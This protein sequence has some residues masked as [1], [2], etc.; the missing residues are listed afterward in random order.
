MAMP[1]NQ[2]WLPVFTDFIKYLR[3]DSK[4]IAAVDDRG[5]ELNLWDSQLIFLKEVC[6]GLDKGIRY[7]VCLKSRQLGVTTISLV[8]DCF[9]LAMHPGTIGALVTDSDANR[10]AN[11]SV[12]KRYISSFPKGFF[13]S[14]FTIVKDNR[15]FME[16]SNGS[17]LDFLVAGTREKK[18][19]GEGRGYALAHLTEVA[20][21]GSQAGLANFKESLA[22]QNPNR[23]VIMES[24]AN[25]FNL[26]KNEWDEAGRDTHT[27]KR[28]FI[29]WWSKN[30]SR[31]EKDDPRYPIYGYEDPDPDERELMK[32]VKEEYDYT[33]K[34]EQLAWYRWK[35][36]DNS[37]SEA[38][39]LQNQPWMASQAFVLSGY[40]FFQVRQLQKD[41]AR[42]VD[43]DGTPDGEPVT[44]KGFRYWLG[45]DFQAGK[46]ERIVDQ[47]RLNEVE[48]RVWEEPVSGAQYVIGCD[49][50]FGRNDHKDRHGISVWR[51]YA[52][53]LVQVAEYA[54]NNVETRQAAWVLAFLAGTYRNCMV[55]IDLTGGPGRAVLT[56]FEHLKERMRSDMYAE[57]VKEYEWD[58]FLSNARWYLYHRPDSFGAGYAKGTIIGG[59]NKFYICNAM[60]DSYASGLLEINSKPLIEE[61]LTVVQDGGTIGAPGN[62]KDD[63]VF[64]GILANI[65]WVEWIRPGMIQRGDTYQRLTDAE[66]GELQAGRAIVGNIVSNFFKNAEERAEE[67]D[68]RPKWLVDRGLA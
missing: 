45:N 55:N 66:N 36:S 50:A 9:W 57:T 67:E 6:Y 14:S 24:T 13:G 31:I 11:R 4:E 37:K 38:D 43:G 52:D 46:M 51:C 47:E 41:M 29:G 26:Y 39:I 59:D 19:W 27:K 1:T 42:I 22:E 63:R 65:S 16:F 32:I 58:D 10:E 20:K 34:P 17:R 48:L 64:A 30:I 53:R 21:Y 3:I 60:R 5:S 35:A 2:A 8:V 40:S 28:I 49:P 33:I 61:M 56:E 25:G 23:L 68:E 54:D 44:F 62:A 12:I 15:N 18:N 7:F